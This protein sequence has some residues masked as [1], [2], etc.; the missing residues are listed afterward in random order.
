M[1]RRTLGTTL[2]R[3]FPFFFYGNVAASLMNMVAIT[4]NR[5]VLISC[6]GYY[7][8]IYSR[9]NIVLMVLTVWAFSFGMILPPLIEVGTVLCTEE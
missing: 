2:C 3:I 9:T 4:V 7:A 1:Y 8:T 6:H 5:Y